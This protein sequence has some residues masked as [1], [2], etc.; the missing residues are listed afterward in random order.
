MGYEKR[1]K[2]SPEERAKQ[3]LPFSA[4]RGLEE[5]LE[6]KRQELFVD[7]PHIL[8]SDAEEEINDTLKVIDNGDIVEIEYYDGIRNTSFSGSV[9]SVRNK[10][11]EIVVDGKVIS[12]EV[13]GRL[14]IKE[15]K[16]NT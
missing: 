16:D 6:R 1:L 7:V 2:M 8:C 15:K 9:D 10:N 4:V 13:V 5:A 14:K 3:F 12:F 11:K